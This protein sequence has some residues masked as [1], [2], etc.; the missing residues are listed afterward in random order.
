MA[1]LSTGLMSCNQDFETIFSPLSNEPESLLQVS[2]VSVA[3]TMPAAINLAEYFDL[4]AGTTKAI[5]IGNVTVKEGAMPANTI[6]KAEVEFSKDAD[7]AN[8]IVLDAN[9][10]EDTNVIS[11][12]PSILQDAY[13][14]EVTRNPATAELFVRTVLYTV[15]GGTAVAIVGK[16]GENYFAERS[17]QFTPL[18]KVNI[19][20]AY[21]YVGATNGW[22][23]SDKTYKFDNGGGDPYENPVFTCT[24]PAPYNEDGTRA[25][26]WFKIAPE[27]AYTSGN[28]WGGL[29]GVK[30]DGDTSTEGM[31][32]GPGNV[33]AFNQ[34]ASDGATM[35]RITLNMLENTYSITPIT[36]KVEPAYYYV[37][38][39]NGW[40][41]SD[42]TYK[43]TNGGA[44]PFENPVYTCTV[45]APFNEDGTRADNWFK[46]APESA[47]TSGNFWGNL[48]GVENNGDTSTSG[49][50]AFGDVG[51]FNQPAS[52][53]AL[54]YRIT[55]NPK[56]MTYNIT[57]LNF[58]E[59][60]WEAGVNNNW[61]SEAQPLYCG[62]GNGTYKGF[63]YAQDADWSGGKGA[64]KFQKEFNNW[65]VNYGF[66][67][68][69]E[70]AGT[71]AEGADNIMVTPG[72]YYAEID[73]VALTYKL[74]PIT[75]IGIVGPAQ[76]NGWGGDTDMT[77][78]PETRAWEATLEM[79]ADEFKFRANDDWAINWGGSV[80]NLTQDG[81]N[82][83]ISEA[84]TYFVQFFPICETKSYCV[85]TKK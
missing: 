15:T 17:V 76:A 27:S 21:Y 34:P 39:T 24:I 57:P 60:L 67:G 46:I 18:F 13:F 9:S 64:F 42:K 45:P 56:E 74:T 47:Y 32:D 51:A 10:L 72:F 23:D 66:G 77:Y 84:G 62:D 25:D 48:F 78:N 4:E 40:S 1:L 73:L 44:D 83:K 63:F 69:D 55:I 52:D 36:F 16:P 50:L 58:A 43:F 41:D 12:N 65:D 68:G 81:A 38:A 85:I 20:P 59:Y 49:S 61:G 31:L 79:A 5:P 6:L 33:G 2:D 71:L 28:F 29:I 26:N 53:G 37:G 82:L 70:T 7:F 14:N 3:S 80:D 11:V 35:Y 8:S 19:E 75:T 22:S 54:F 30:K